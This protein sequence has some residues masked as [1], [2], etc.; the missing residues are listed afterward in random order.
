MLEKKTEVVKKKIEIMIVAAYSTVCV[1]ETL[2]VALQHSKSFSGSSVLGCWAITQR[3]LRGHR[4]ATE[5]TD[6]DNYRHASRL[7]EGPIVG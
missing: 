2:N 5:S 4:A 7:C 1:R 3:S 6:L